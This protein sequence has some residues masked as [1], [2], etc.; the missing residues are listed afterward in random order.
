MAPARRDGHQIA[1]RPAIANAT[2]AIARAI[3]SRGVTPN[4]LAFDQAPRSERTDNAEREAGE[5]D[6]AALPQEQ[7][8]DSPRVGAD[9]Q[10]HG[11][12]T[13]ALADGIG[14]HAVDAHESEQRR[15][16]PQTHRAARRGISAG[17]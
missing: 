15:D 10:P 12:L 14:D 17:P 16:A 5:K 4:E 1:A 6:D 3:G 8:R 13:L 7:P 11:D 2:T 9:G